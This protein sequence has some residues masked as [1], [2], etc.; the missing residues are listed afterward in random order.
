MLPIKQWIVLAA[1]CCPALAASR[2]SE[3][4]IVFQTTFGD[5][6]MAVYPE[7]APITARHILKLAKLGAYNSVHFFRVDKGFVAQ[8]ADVVYG[9]L[10]GVALDARQMEYGDKFVPL[11]V[12][13]EVKHDKRGILSMGRHSDPDSGKSSFSIL[14]GPAPHLDME[15]TIF[16]EVTKGFETLTK[17]EDVETKRDGIFVM[18]KE[19]ITIHSSYVYCDKCEKETAFHKKRIDSLSKELESLRAARLPGA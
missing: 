10:E 12:I 7:V 3:E 17:F 19:R 15:Y 4:R 1:L 8:T 6:E 16:G 5:I 2:L 14:L 9:R 18:P 13:P 11:E